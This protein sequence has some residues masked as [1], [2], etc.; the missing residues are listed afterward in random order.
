MLFFSAFSFFSK[1]LLT[2]PSFCANCPHFRAY[3]KGLETN[4]VQILLAELF[5]IRLN[6]LYF[7]LNK[8]YYMSVKPANLRFLLSLGST[9]IVVLQDENDLHVYSKKH[10]KTTH[11][12]AFIEPE[13]VVQA[14]AGE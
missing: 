5:K 11:R 8:E 3:F 6:K 4:K 12:N 14:I 10:A 7:V 9:K 13:H 2:T 1:K